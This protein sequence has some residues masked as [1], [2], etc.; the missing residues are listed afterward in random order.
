MDRTRSWRRFR[1]GC[2]IARK[3][4]VLRRKWGAEEV[5]IWT[6]GETGRLAKGKIHCSCRMCR[7]KSRDERSAPDRRAQISMQQ[8]TREET[9]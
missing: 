7:R 1:R 4:G 9:I 2:A 8:Q 6:G 5:K 3:A